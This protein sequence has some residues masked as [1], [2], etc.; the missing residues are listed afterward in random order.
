MGLLETL[1]LGSYVYTTSIVAWLNKKI[2]RAVSNHIKS[3]EARVTELEK[4]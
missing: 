4:K 2:D 1:V 3:L